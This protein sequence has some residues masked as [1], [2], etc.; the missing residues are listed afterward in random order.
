MSDFVPPPFTS[1]PGRRSLTPV[2]VTGTAPKET[3]TV[4]LE[5]VPFSE[6]DLTEG[7]LQDLIFRNPTLLAVE[8]IE[9]DYGP[10]IPL[11]REV[12]TP[13]GPVDG[14][15]ISPDGLITLVEAKL[16]RNPEA[17]RVVVAQILDYAKHLSAWTYDELDEQVRKVRGKGVW[18]VVADANQD[19]VLGED[20]FIDAVTRNLRRGR[21]L[22]LLV[23]DGIRESVEEMA[24]FLQGTP[25]LRFTLA[26]VELGLYR[27]ADRSDLLVVPSVVARTREVVRAV[28][29]VAEL[30][31]VHRIR[32]AEVTTAEGRTAAQ[33]STR[34]KVSSEEF[35]ATMLEKSGPAAVR[36]V[37]ELE[38]GVEQRGLRVEMGTASM[39][40][41]LGDPGGSGVDFTLFGINREGRFFIGWLG[42]QTVN[43]G[44]EF[45]GSPAER[46]ISCV[47][48][49]FGK[50]PIAKDRPQLE[51]WDKGVWLQDANVPVLSLL[52]CVDAYLR[53][54]RSE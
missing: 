6:R 53:D 4:N 50:V 37:R 15:F 12:G 21:F 14:L 32:A 40:V 41:K 44:L 2:L 26:M 18:T 20:E 33:D 48:S 17:R 43:A 38:N 46:Y 30:A 49:L 42:R 10:L 8:E 5:R 36:W 25:H 39:M 31:A 23:G 19:G 52:Q 51:F 27:R 7:W 45:D 22:L 3:T 11:G 35:Y 29:E 34:G 9:P 13:S 54:I 24:G 1:K 28:V 16:W 47:S